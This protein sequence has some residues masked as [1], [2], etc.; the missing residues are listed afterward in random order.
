MA[1]GPW[2]ESSPPLLLGSG[3]YE[4]SG[5]ALEARTNGRVRGGNQ[6]PRSGSPQDALARPAIAGRLMSGDPLTLVRDPSVSEVMVNG[7]DDV[8]GE[9]EG[10]IERVPDRLFEKEEPVLHLMG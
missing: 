9:R 4:S 5:P 10:R 3:A 6:T 1:V 2:P 7:P 8:F